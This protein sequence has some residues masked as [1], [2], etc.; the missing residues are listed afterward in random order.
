MSF[1]FGNA[2][3]YYTYKNAYC[4]LPRV[5]TGYILLNAFILYFPI[6]MGKHLGRSSL[7]TCNLV[8][9]TPNL[10]TIIQNLQDI[11]KTNFHNNWKNDNAHLLH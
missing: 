10:V 2:N 9:I 6:D 5:H 7:L 8:I 1:I 11:T 4:I 3:F